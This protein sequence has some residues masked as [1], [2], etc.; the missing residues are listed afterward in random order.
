[1]FPYQPFQNLFLH[2]YVNRQSQGTVKFGW[3]GGEE[4]TQCENYTEHKIF[5]NIN[6]RSLFSLS[7]C[8]FHPYNST[9]KTT[10]P[11]PSSSSRFFS[12]SFWN[13]F[14]LANICFLPCISRGKTLDNIRFIFFFA[15][16]ITWTEHEICITRKHYPC[17]NRMI[18]ISSM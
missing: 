17:K 10:L 1:M 15:F 7:H 6:R 16:K 3:G 13:I 11:P 12:L 4:C 2:Y 18:C 8:Q 14:F 9:Q 5:F